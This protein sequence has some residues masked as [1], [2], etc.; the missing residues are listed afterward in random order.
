M[1]KAFTMLE[2]IFVLVVIG[3]IAAVVLPRTQRSPLQEAGIQLLS[4]IRYTQH[5]AIMDDKYD[6]NDVNWSHNRW[7]LLFGKSSAAAKNTGGYYAYSIFSDANNDGN[8]NTVEM[9]KN[10]QDTS[11]FLSGG[12]SSA[13]DWEDTKATQTL[14]IGYKYGITNVT[15]GGGCPNNKG[16]R[17]AFDHSGRP[18]QGNLKT[19]TG[20]YSGTSGSRLITT[21]CTITLTDGTNNLIITVAPETGYARITQ[22]Q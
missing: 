8:P 19:L 4:D 3:I 18:L 20:V 14:N 9:A 13:L 2:L 17:I 21:D 5:L 6:T 22:F 7:Q 1:R 16:K 10:P 15:F 12:F 11:K